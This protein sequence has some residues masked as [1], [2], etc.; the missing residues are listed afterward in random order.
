M[1]GTALP[2]SWAG[3]A[4]QSYE[5]MPLATEHCSSAEVL[6]FRDYAFH[7][8]FE[9]PRYLK[10]IEQKFGKES[11]EHI[12]EMTKIRLKRTGAGCYVNSFSRLLVTKALTSIYHSELSKD[13]H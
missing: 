10:F 1:E 13:S 7:A 2:N 4:S 8:Y 3:Y 9:N 5:F 12:Q 11:R 6:A